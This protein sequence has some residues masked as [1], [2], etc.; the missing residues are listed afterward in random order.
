MILLVYCIV[1][2]FCYVFVLS[3]ALRDIFPTSMARYSLF[4]LKVPLNTNEPNHFLGPEP[5]LAVISTLN[6]T[7][8][9]SM[10]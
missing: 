2:L 1:S 6:Q 3:P 9:Q 5:A 4:V 7:Y 10:L 8:L